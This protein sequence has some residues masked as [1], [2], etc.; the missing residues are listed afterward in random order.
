MK[1]GDL[2]KV[3]ADFDDFDL[4]EIGIVVEFNGRNQ[5]NHRTHSLL[6]TS[7][8]IQEYELETGTWRFEVINESR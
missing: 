2:V 8:K 1:K 7:G 5:K 4:S 3:I 6:L